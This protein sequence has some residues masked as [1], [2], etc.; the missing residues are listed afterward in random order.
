MTLSDDMI[1][2]ARHSDSHSIYVKYSREYV[3]GR[4][5]VDTWYAYCGYPGGIRH[6]PFDGS[7]CGL[8]QA[9]RTLCASLPAISGDG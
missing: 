6:V 2:I 5:I 8:E 9:V 7:P 4:G 3:M 1:A